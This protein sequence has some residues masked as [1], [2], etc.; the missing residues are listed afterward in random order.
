MFQ[1]T[2]KVLLISRSHKNIIVTVHYEVYVG[3]PL[4]S[5]WISVA[6]K[7]ASRDDGVRVKMVAVENV[8]TNWQWSQQGSNPQLQFSLFLFSRGYET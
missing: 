8:A 3:L 1:A 4:I 7:S 5:K 2:A 6:L